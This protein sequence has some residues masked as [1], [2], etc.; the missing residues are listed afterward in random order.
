MS[1]V[2]V[3]SHGSELPFSCFREEFPVVFQKSQDC[4]PS[5]HWRQ[6]PCPSIFLVGDRALSTASRNLRGREGMEGRALAVTNRA[7]PSGLRPVSAG[8]RSA[9]IT[10]VHA[11]CPSVPLDRLAAPASAVVSHPATAEPHHPPP[12]RSARR[13]PP[14]QRHD[15]DGMRHSFAPP[16]LI[17]QGDE[18]RTAARAARRHVPL[19]VTRSP[20]TRFRRRMRTARC[21][22]GRAIRARPLWPSSRRTVRAGS[23]GPAG[24]DRTAGR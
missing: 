4:A 11:H 3:A 6:H 18:P 20:A 22:A 1:L 13:A 23:H 2:L 8:P 14:L 21:A 16:R 12:S 10:A 7:L 17:A 24:P 9:P 15:E 5:C 19:P